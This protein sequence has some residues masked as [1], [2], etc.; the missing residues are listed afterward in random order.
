MKLKSEKYN[1]V[2]IDFAQS[3]NGMVIAYI[4]KK[5]IGMYSVKRT[6]LI[7]A[8]NIIDKNYNKKSLSKEDKEKQMLNDNNVSFDEYYNFTSQNDM[9]YIDGINDREIIQQY[10][11]EMMEKGIIVSHMLKALEDSDADL[12]EIWLGNSMLTPE[13]IE[14]KQKLHDALQL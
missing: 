14:T 12:F 6:A 4:D 8:K 11:S 13:P 7:D 3:A 10:I 2:R 9:G 5:A 1:N